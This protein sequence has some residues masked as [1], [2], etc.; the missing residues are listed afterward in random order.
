MPHQDAHQAKGRQAGLLTDQ[1]PE[2]LAARP[3]HAMACQVASGCKGDGVFRGIEE[4]ES[5]P[6]LCQQLGWL[7][8]KASEDTRDSHGGAN[9][10]DPVH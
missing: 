1:E 6:H 5:E 8:T 2:V 3:G 9:T 4:P 10:D 7:R